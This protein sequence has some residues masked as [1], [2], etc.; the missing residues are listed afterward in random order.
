[1]PI[2]IKL[3][4]DGTSESPYRCMKKG[5]EDPDKPEIGIKCS[6]CG[7]TIH[8]K[9]SSLENEE[10]AEA[11]GE[12]YCVPECK[13]SAKAKGEVTVLQK[14][15]DANRLLLHGLTKRF[16]QKE[17]EDAARQ[18]EL[19]K[20]LER[21][22]LLEEEN[23]R[24]SQTQNN[25]AKVRILTSTTSQTLSDKIVEEESAEQITEEDALE[26][27]NVSESNDEFKH[28][29][30]EIFKQPA[31]PRTESNISISRQKSKA[32]IDAMSEAE[33][34]AYYQRLHVQRLEAPKLMRYA[35]D[36]AEWLSFK[37]NY[38][39]MKERGEYD[40]ETMVDKLRDSLN[41]EAERYVKPRLN[42]PFAQAD[43]IMEALQKRF[44]QPKEA[45]A[46]AWERLESWTQIPDKNRK[47]LENFMVEIDSY[48]F[49]CKDLNFQ[50]E[51]EIAINSRITNKL[52]YSIESKWHSHIH[53]KDL[54]GNIVEFSDF[55]WSFVPNLPSREIQSTNNSQS[56]TK[57][58]INVAQ[59]DESERTKSFN[60]KK[61]RKEK[62][63][64]WYCGKDK[65]HP[66]YRCEEFRKLSY[67][68][69]AVFLAS[70]KLCSKCLASNQHTSI[71]CPR[72]TRIPKC[73]KNQYS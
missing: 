16:E 22:K 12:W 55:M 17:K 15:L 8:L 33:K 57:A 19:S 11:T 72:A 68:E 66:L 6:Y 14:Q 63:D 26:M 45:V 21:I 39:R 46:K 5:C 44:F 37:A 29:L 41:G 38:E 36:P 60:T 71:T 27:F 4:D 62:P 31:L 73:N 51:L 34:L 49:L 61:V 47:S 59:R 65:K 7:R 67:D 24:L 3:K 64:C 35:G 20:C 56:R 10:N 48:I 30:T 13:K 28:R 50:P 2:L 32:E 9:C 54:R 18:A 70:N 58:S 42:Q 52:P 69:K 43:L 25:A 40:N 23:R 53:D 1:M